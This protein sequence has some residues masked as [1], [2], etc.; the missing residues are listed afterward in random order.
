MIDFFH[1]NQNIFLK[2]LLF[3]NTKFEKHLREIKIKN[4]YSVFFVCPLIHTKVDIETKR[5]THFPNLI[6]RVTKI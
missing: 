4:K 3:I 5:I 1:F 6:I 2:L